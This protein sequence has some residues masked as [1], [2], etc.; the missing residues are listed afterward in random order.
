MTTRSMAKK[1][2]DAL[3]TPN[4]I[5]TRFTEAAPSALAAA[6]SRISTSLL[7]K[8]AWDGDSSSQNHVATTHIPQAS[9]YASAG[10]QKPQSWLV[11]AA[12]FPPIGVHGGEYRSSAKALYLYRIDRGL[13]Q[14]GSPGYHAE[15]KAVIAHDGSA[16]MRTP[17][18][19]NL[20]STSAQDLWGRICTAR[21]SPLED[22]YLRE[23]FDSIK[24]GRSYLFCLAAHED[25]MD[26]GEWTVVVDDVIDTTDQL[27]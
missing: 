19:A 15:L 1:L 11:T 25:E 2:K 4:D 22:E 7:P 23:L 27:Q 26:A 24:E 17:A 16:G 21:T 9:V 3:P 14:D 18:I 12:V 20:D 5:L 13:N 6:S 8:I 10:P